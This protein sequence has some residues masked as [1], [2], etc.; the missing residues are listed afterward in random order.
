MRWIA[1]TLASFDDPA[2]WSP[3]PSAVE[4]YTQRRLKDLAEFSGSLRVPMVSTAFVITGLVLKGGMAWWP[5]L[6]WL[7]GVLVVRELQVASLRRLVHDPRSVEVRMRRAALNKLPLGLVHGGSGLFMLG[8]G[9]EYDALLTMILMSL[10][11]GAVSTTFMV[12]RGYLA[13]ASSVSLSTA[14]IWLMSGT[15]IG[16]SVGVLVSMFFVVQLRF[17][18]QNMRMY[19]ES[20]RMRLENLEL[21]QALSAEQLSLTHARD[22]AVDA[23]L[24][25]SRF[26]ASASHDLRQPLQSLSLNSGALGRLPLDGEARIIGAEISQGI[27]AL[28]QMLDA[29]LDVSKLD[30]GAV[31]PT[32]QQI[33]LHRLVDGL[34][35]RLQPIAKAKGLEVSC[36]C[37]TDLVVLSDAD[38]LRRVVANL[39][40]NAIKFTTRGHVRLRAEAA[41]A[42]VRL[43]VSDTGCGIDPA[44]LHRVF[45]DLVQLQ[46]PQRDRALGFGLGLGIVRRLTQML[47]IR[48]DVDSRPD[49][50]TE[51]VLWLPC[52]DNRAAVVTETSAVLPAFVARRVLVLD[53][54]TAV[55][56]AYAHMLD[57]HDCQHHC[58]ATLEDAVAAIATLRPE[59]ALVDF[60]LSGGLDGLQCISRLRD[61]RPGLAAVIVSA[62]TSMDMRDAAAAAQVLVLRKPVTDAALAIAVNEALHLAAPAWA[63]VSFN[64]EGGRDER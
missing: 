61:I 6:V 35:A 2:G 11:A 30:A 32:I 60:R 23:D 29:L 55:R 13:Y 15:W 26:L 51:F 54:D 56:N 22:A 39:M 53:D 27:E 33:P 28:R 16:A 20:Y 38:L 34:C 1:D 25:K 45:D 58:A 3:P 10:S 7:V 44:D 12:P 64:D 41:G 8:M 17:A 57:S 46:N 24:A 19:Q 50:G 4:D 47:S 9:T 36:E 37:P 63:A 5:A 40:D 48:Y 49:Q 31:T 14:A 62:D 52:G 42:V 59:V 18:R 43:R 21:L